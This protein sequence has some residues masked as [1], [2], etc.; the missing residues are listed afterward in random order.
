MMPELKL[1]IVVPTYNR[2]A[3]IGPAIESLLAST[4]TNFEILVIDDGS[5]DQTEA[6]IKNYSDNRIR[7]IKQENRE[8]GAARNNGMQNATGE[9]IG[10]LDSDDIVLPDHLAQAVDLI[11]KNP[12]QDVF[13]L[14]YKIE[15]KEKNRTVI[16]P[17]DINSALIKGNMLSC[18]GVFF[19]HKIAEQFKFSE[20]RSL[21]ALEDWELWL[22]IASS[23][24]IVSS[25]AVTSIIIQH[26]D[27][28]VLQTTKEKIETRFDS[29]FKHVTLN[30]Q[31]VAFYKGRMRFLKASG[32]TYMA[33]HLAMT[34]K[35]RA[36][37]LK[38]LWKGF[39][40][41]PEIIFSRRFY[42]ILKRIP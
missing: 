5:T 8:R 40:H 21:S 3:H 13:V 37:A 27:R 32:E 12:L 24:K 1:S 7:Y 18:N 29:F 38:H 4:Y 25:P 28:S 22:R 36:A 30:P 31:V 23:R 20:D 15:E 17:D 33:L 41:S 39:F 14:S 34:K 19:R 42:A 16:L 11:Q 6:V 26:D 2:A 9:I 10:F 35:N